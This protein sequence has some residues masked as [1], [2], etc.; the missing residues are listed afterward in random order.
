MHFARAAA[1]TAASTAEAALRFALGTAIGATAGR[2]GKSALVV[3]FLF[4]R[5]ED[6]IF[7]AFAAGQ[8]FVSVAHSMH[9]FVR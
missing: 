9:S 3:E 4:T 2:V 6:E 1:A 7:S 8:V 5:G